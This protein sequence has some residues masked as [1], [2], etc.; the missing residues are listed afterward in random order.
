[1]ATDR[2]TVA[3]LADRM[4]GLEQQIGALLTS[5]GEV[6]QSVDWLRES[7]GKESERVW[8]ALSGIAGLDGVARGLVEITEV[9]APLHSVIPPTT[10][11]PLE[12]GVGRAL[13]QVRAALGPD[14]DLNFPSLV[15]RWDGPVGFIG[16]AESTS[17]PPQTPAARDGDYQEVVA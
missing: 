10:A 11:V 14:R 7:S 9:L 17:R 3:Q 15:T 13:G 6:H 2:P 12:P 16:Q 4:E 8:T 1:M 5:V